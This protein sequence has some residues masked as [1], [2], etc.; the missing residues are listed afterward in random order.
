MI[1]RSPASPKSSTRE[2]RKSGVKL[3]ARYSPD[4]LRAIWEFVGDLDSFLDFLVWLDSLPRLERAE[5]VKAALQ[6]REH[7]RNEADSPIG[8]SGEPL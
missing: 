3:S 7:R 2:L 6:I 5:Q 8:S 4:E 1:R